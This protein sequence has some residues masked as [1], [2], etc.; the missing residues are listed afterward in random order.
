MIAADQDRIIWQ[1]ILMLLEEIAEKDTTVRVNP[2]VDLSEMVQAVEHLKGP[3]SA[4]EIAEALAKYLAPADSG[5]N[6]LAVA[7]NDIK[8]Q[9]AKLPRTLREIGGA[10]TIVAGPNI[11]NDMTRQLGKVDVENF[12]ATQ[13]VSVTNTAVNVTNSTATEIGTGKFQMYTTGRLELAVAGNVRATITN[14][15]GSGKTI[16]MHRLAGLASAGPDWATLWINPTTGLPAT[17]ARTALNA[18][19][20]GGV[21]NVGQVKADTSATTPL[22]GGTDPGIVFGIPAAS[23]FELNL[24]PLILAAGVTL[25][26]NVPFAGA[27][28]AVMSVYTTEV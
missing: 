9:L 10:R 27:A 6:A 25:G 26:I 3:A 1:R 14:P 11:P 8:D 16:K 21:P 12:P 2:Q 22:G 24:P 28:T 5:N 4:I 7:M 17:A 19:V 13:N 23:R 15:V 20:G 18:I